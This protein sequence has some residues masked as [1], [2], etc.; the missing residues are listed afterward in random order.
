M[1]AN[2]GSASPVAK[3]SA[4]AITSMV[5]GILS[6]CTFLI[7]APFAIIFGIISLIMIAKSKGRLKGMGFAI[8]GIAVPVAALPFVAI[9]LGVMLPALVRARDM[10]QRAVCMSNLKQLGVA[11]ITYADNNK[12]QYPTADKWC[13]L[14]EPYYGNNG[15]VLICPAT[16][17]KKYDYTKTID[18]NAKHQCSYA[19]NPNAKRDCRFPA[20]T[21]FLFESNPGWNQSG[22][23]ELATTQNHGEKACNVLFCDG[24]VEFVH[25]EDI[26]KLRWTENQ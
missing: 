2:I 8:T 25:A 24:H 23:S 13:D 6:F 7:T 9:S 26:N 15:N 22:G 5:L 21:V 18:P 20:G 12:G 10:G 19:I 17:N 1:L 11:A 16:R 14:L 4:L 3:T